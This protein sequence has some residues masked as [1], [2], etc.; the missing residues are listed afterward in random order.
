MPAQQGRGGDEEDIPRRAGKQ[1]RQSR[2]HDPISRLEIGT[3][4]LTAQYG[5]L[6]TK[7]HDL[8]RLGPI[9]ATQQDQ[10]LEDTPEDEV[11]KE[12]FPS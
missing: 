6:M 4:H 5:Q 12:P 3:V 1:P 10:E 8:G 2:E 9:T 7:H 11:E